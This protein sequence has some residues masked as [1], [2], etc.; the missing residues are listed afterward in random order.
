MAYSPIID[1][2]QHTAWTFPPF[3]YQQHL[4]YAST[5]WNSL[6][7]P[8][9]TACN[10]LATPCAVMQDNS[11]P[12]HNWPGSRQSNYGTLSAT[13]VASL[14]WSNDPPAYAPSSF[15]PTADVG[16]YNNYLTQLHPACEFV[17][18][19]TNL[20]SFSHR[21]AHYGA[22]PG[23]VLTYSPA[24]NYSS[25][26][27]DHQ[28][29]VPTDQA[30]NATAP[31]GLRSKPD[32]YRVPL[33]SPITFPMVPSPATTSLSTKPAMNALDSPIKMKIKQEE[34]IPLSCYCQKPDDEDM[35]ECFG[36][37][38]DDPRSM[39]LGCAGLESPPS[40]E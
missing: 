29:F 23:R 20:E 40:S 28:S 32:L 15:V 37:T 22:M 30:V 12:A 3:R 17:S 24:S 13:D 8:M 14:P 1:M 39:H 27:N 21:A 16:H 7:T 26:A 10:F 36:P 35:V 6:L 2:P 11:Y 4:P 38:H 31:S 34:D 25:I 19:P 18:S 5:D 33:I 9:V